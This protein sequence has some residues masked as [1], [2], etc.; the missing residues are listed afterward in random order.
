MTPALQGGNHADA[1]MRRAA[2]LEAG[3]SEGDESDDE[4]EEEA[5][6]SP[7]DHSQDSA[8]EEEE[9]EAGRKQA[10]LAAMLSLG[11]E[12][13]AGLDEGTRAAIEQLRSQPDVQDATPPVG[14]LQQ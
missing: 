9:M 2:R 5:A 11:L 6:G 13:L 10:Q 4:S 3:Q 1:R 14:H 12:D 7:V 8:D